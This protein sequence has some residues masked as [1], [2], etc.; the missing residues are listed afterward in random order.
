M[1]KYTSKSLPSDFVNPFKGRNPD[2]VWK[3]LQC[4]SR[5][6]SKE[7]ETK[8]IQEANRLQKED[9]EDK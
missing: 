4:S 3:E 2:E 7:E 1:S 9:K 5:P 8:I 6:L